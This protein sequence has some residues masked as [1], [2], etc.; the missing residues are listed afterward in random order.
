MYV[1]PTQNVTSL[2]RCVSWDF[3][4]IGMHTVLDITSNYFVLSTQ[5][6]DSLTEHIIL[7]CHSLIKYFYIS[8]HFSLSLTAP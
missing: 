7:S 3:N 8:V 6:Q 4:F 5:A 2:P 1:L